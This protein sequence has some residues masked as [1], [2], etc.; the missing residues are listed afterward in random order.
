MNVLHKSVSIIALILFNTYSQQE[1][2]CIFTKKSFES[3]IQKKYSKEYSVN[4]S[5]LKNVN[6]NSNEADEKNYSD[7]DQHEF[8]GWVLEQMQRLIIIL[9]IIILQ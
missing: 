3:L 9:L 7:E 4:Y 8:M 6:D 1:K 5:L 2:S